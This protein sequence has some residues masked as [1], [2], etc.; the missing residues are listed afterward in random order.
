MSEERYQ[1]FSTVFTVKD[2]QKSLDFYNKVGFKTEMTAPGPG[3]KLMH[4]EVDY[5]GS[6]LMLGPSMEGELKNVGTGVA[7]YIDVPSA[8]KAFQQVK[9]A[10]ARIEEEPKDQFWGRRDFT[11][12][13]PDGY[14][15]VFS[16]FVRKVTPEEMEK[17][18]MAMAN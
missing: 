13:D 1:G 15:L 4:A 9:A 14:K 11:A 8:D 18:M 6:T 17:A 16:Q 2:I 10:G 3:G 12:L 5:H 7:L